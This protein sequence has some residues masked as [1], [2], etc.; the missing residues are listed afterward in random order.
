MSAVN[1][2]IHLFSIFWKFRSWKEGNIGKCIFYK[3]YLCF[4]WGKQHK[5]VTLCDGDY[6]LQTQRLQTINS[7][8]FVLKFCCWPWLLMLMKTC[9]GSFLII[10]VSPFEIIRE[11][12]R[13]MWR[14][15]KMSINSTLFS[16]DVQPKHLE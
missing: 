15:L 1:T 12:N 7:N 3:S 11:C 5:Y 14:K 4:P 2:S 13:Q 16:L 6:F 9:H 8:L 10:Y